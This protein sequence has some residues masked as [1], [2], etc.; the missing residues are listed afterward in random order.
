VPR[1]SKAALPRCTRL[2]SINSGPNDWQK[3]IIKKLVLGD[4]G[5]GWAP[6]HLIAVMYRLPNAWWIYI[7]RGMSHMFHN[8][9][10]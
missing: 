7:W 10:K 2:F 4:T 5:H 1:I 8:S 3:Y 6:E 9:K